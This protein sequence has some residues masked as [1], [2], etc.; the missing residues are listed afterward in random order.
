MNKSLLQKYKPSRLDEFN[1]NDYYKKL[2]NI[3]LNSNKLHFLIQ[4][5]CCV[6]KSSLINVL[7][8]IYYADSNVEE[9]VMYFN[10]LKDQGINYYRNELKNYCQINNMLN[11]V[12]KTVVID[13]LDLLNEQSQQFFYTLITNF[14]NINYIF[15]CNNINKIDQNIIQKLE[16]L[17]IEN[18]DEAFLER[19]LQNINFHE[20]IQMSANN[21]NEII[22]SSNY[23]IP[24][25]INILEKILIYNNNISNIYSTHKEQ[26]HLNDKIDYESLNL[27]IQEL[28]TYLELC[29]NSELREAIKFISNINNSGY[30]V[31]DIL[32]ELVN[33]VKF[34]SDFEDEYKYKI[35]KILLK[36]INIFNNLH[37]DEIELIFLTN[38]L[39]EVLKKKKK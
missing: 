32:D 3:Y 15:S 16:V 1:I 9:N 38:N 18:T 6:G 39:I 10:I 36:Y 31:I 35:L 11:N 37:E 19:I 13:D 4:G 23:C 27:Q 17:K 22:N 24:K 33:Y 20:N 29:K 7:L 2:I 34:Y 21:L 30:S 28:H 5:N 12:K 26:I 25:M 8:N 14:H